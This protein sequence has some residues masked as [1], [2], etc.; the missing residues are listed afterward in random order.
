VQVV[1]STPYGVT[2]V[3]LGQEQPAIK[4]GMSA[5]IIARMP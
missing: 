3:V 4:E 2:A 5:R 1:R